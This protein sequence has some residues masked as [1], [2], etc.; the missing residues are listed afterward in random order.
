MTFNLDR[1]LFGS[2]AKRRFA[3][4]DV[5]VPGDK[6]YP[7]GALT[8]D[9]WDGET[10]KAYPV[11]GGFGYLFP[12]DRIDHYDFQVVI[13]ATP[14]IRDLVTPRVAPPVRWRRALFYLGEPEEGV[15]PGYHW[16]NR[17]NGWATPSFTEKVARRIVRD[18]NTSGTD[19][20]FV[21]DAPNNRVCQ[22]DWNELTREAAD[23]FGG[24]L[25][26]LPPPDYNDYNEDYPW[27]CFPGV[28]EER[29][30]IRM[31]TLFGIGDGWIWD[32]IDPEDVD[33]SWV[34]K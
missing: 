20:E 17:W 1:E 18:F 23:R 21:F 13:P 2:R 6:E 10:L 5:I 12:L 7:E 4:G 8:V 28:R 27:S 33:P 3:K 22:W 16:G 14:S 30:G 34:K 25:P 32:D 19:W 29:N 15:Y 9:S 11:G 31:M 24:V 26:A